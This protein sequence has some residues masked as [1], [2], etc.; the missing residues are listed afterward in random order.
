[1]KVRELGLAA[2]WLRE[3]GNRVLIFYM[4]MAERRSNDS[5]RVFAKREENWFMKCCCNDAWKGKA[6][7]VNLFYFQEFQCSKIAD[8]GRMLS[9]FPALLDL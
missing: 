2:G 4:E 8:Y 3:E 5:R 9:P 6:R 7:K 1:M